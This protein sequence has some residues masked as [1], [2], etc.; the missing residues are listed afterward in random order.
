VSVQRLAGQ[1]TA[2][3]EGALPDGEHRMKLDNVAVLARK[4]GGWG[5]RIISINEAGRYAREWRNLS[6]DA[7]DPF[8]LTDGQR[9]GIVECAKRFNI[10]ETDPQ[11][12][13]EQLQNSMGAPVQVRVKQTPHGTVIKHSAP[14]GIRIRTE[15]G[16]LTVAGEVIEP[17]DAFQLEQ[18]LKAALRIT[19]RSLIDVAEACYGISRNHAYEALGYDTLAEFLAQPDVGMSRS[20][21]FT[22]AKVHEVFV[23]EHGIDPERLA[24]ASLTKL[25]VVLPKVAAGEVDAEEALGDA[26][27]QGLR[28]LRDGYRG[29]RESPGDRTPGCVRCKGIPDE[30]ID[31]LRARWEMT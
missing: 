3:Q 13:V 7:E 14:E 30:A 8:A 27:T 10:T 24:D 6:A 18:K 11:A 17:Q 19:R 1:I 20:E 5:L 25:D 16:T 31:E 21:F 4:K 28:D 29:E 9:K 2:T 26:A 12:I 15:A 23:L 22:A